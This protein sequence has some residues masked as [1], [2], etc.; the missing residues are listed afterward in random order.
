MKGLRKMGK[1]KAKEM[2]F[3]TK[4]E[5]LTSEKQIED[6]PIAHCTFEILY[7][8]GLRLGEPLVLT[9]DDIDFNCGVIMVRRGITKVGS[10]YETSSPKTS[11]SRHVAQMPPFLKEEL[12]A[13]MYPKGG[14]SRMRGYSPS[15]MTR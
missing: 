11:T 8:C 9:G 14:F 10:R 2:S 7:W 12:G 15:H 6:D 4:A 13:V 5:Y 3:W 1:K